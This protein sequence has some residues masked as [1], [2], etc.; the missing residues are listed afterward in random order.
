MLKTFRFAFSALSNFN[1]RLWP[2]LSISQ[3]LWIGIQI[4]VTRHL[5]KM[6]M[7]Y[8]KFVIFSGLVVWWVALGAVR[9]L[10]PWT[11]AYAG[12]NA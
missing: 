6:E 5:K 12:E 2:V 9:S 8:H 11:Y 4:W 3:I 1:I 7:P 10:I